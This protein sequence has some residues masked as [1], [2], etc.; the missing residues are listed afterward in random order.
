MRNN[1]QSLPHVKIKKNSKILP[2]GGRF[3]MLKLDGETH[4]KKKMDMAAPWMQMIRMNTQVVYS[5][6][7]GKQEFRIC[8]FAII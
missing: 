1:F 4:S 7:S 6:G 5:N 8:E 2:G 3:S